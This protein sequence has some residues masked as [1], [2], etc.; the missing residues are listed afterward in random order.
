MLQ[1]EVTTLRK[2][3]N[4][5]SQQVAA[6]PNPDVAILQTKLTSIDERLSVI[7][8]AIL[9]NPERALE[10]TLLNKEMDN[11]KLT[12]QSDRKIHGRKLDEYM[13]LI[14]GLLA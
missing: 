8:R 3:I 7:E 9:D 6:N 14:S 1:S 5:L 4:A 10:L 2:E 11:L 12:Y 13:I